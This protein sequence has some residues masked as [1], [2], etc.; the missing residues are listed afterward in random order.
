MKNLKFKKF[1]SVVTSIAMVAAIFV[2]FPLSASAASV[3]SF[4]VTLTRLTASTEANQTILFTTPTGVT[5]DDTIILTYDN[6]TAIPGAFDFEDV[7]LS[8]Q[9]SPDGVCETGDTQ[10]TLAAAPVTTTMGVVDTSATVITFTNGSTAIAAGSEICIQIGTHATT[11]STGVE[12]IENGDAGTTKLVISGDFGDSGT[13]AMPIIADDQVVI[14]ATVDST[15]SFSISD[16]TIEFGTLGSGAAKWAD[17][18]AGSATDAVA[19]TL[20]V[21]T[22]ATGG[23]SVTYSGATLTSGSDTIDVASLNDNADGNPGTEEF[24]LSIST[25]GDCTIGS[26]YDHAGPDWTW[27]A[28]TTTTICS[29]TVPTATETIS[30][31]YL[32][33][34]SAL[35]E[36]GAYGTTVT[37]IATGTF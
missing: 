13:A 2:Y 5:A 33:N 26:G 27:V 1:V 23:Y 24:G 14:T 11:G 15:I 9:A 4:S 19:H 3:T 31:R 7:D 18:S 28:S 25:S 29:E 37:Y 20:A 32:A 35:T 10:M 12:Q 30:A 17:D 8:F 6:S 34:I 16:N 36:A 21:G 22:N